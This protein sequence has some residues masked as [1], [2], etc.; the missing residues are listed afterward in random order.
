MIVRLECRC[1]SQF[2]NSTLA[3]ANRP[4]HVRLAGSLAALNNFLAT[5]SRTRPAGWP[6]GG[7]VG[8]RG[9]WSHVVPPPWQCMGSAL[10]RFWWICSSESPG[11]KLLQFSFSY[12]FSRRNRKNKRHDSRANTDCTQAWLDMVRSSDDLVAYQ[13]KAL[14]MFLTSKDFVNRTFAIDVL[15]RCYCERAADNRATSSS[16]N[17]L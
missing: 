11:L 2:L 3:S 17:S 13:T 1:F 7:G 6:L 9:V 14:M 10:T 8:R 15:R 5:C 12:S 4:G 16:L